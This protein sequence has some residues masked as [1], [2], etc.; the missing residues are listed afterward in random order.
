M[1]TSKIIVSKLFNQRSL[2]TGGKNSLIIIGG[3]QYTVHKFIA[4]PIVLSPKILGY[5]MRNLK[6]KNQG[7]RGYWAVYYTQSFTIT[8]SNSLAKQL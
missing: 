8:F 1:V 6:S 2:S 3:M 7:G 4:L 5:N